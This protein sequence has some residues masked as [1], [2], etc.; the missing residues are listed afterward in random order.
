MCQS[1]SA[2]V[3]SAVIAMSHMFVKQRTGELKKVSAYHHFRSK[4]TER[5]AKH[6]NR[7]L[8]AV[9][10]RPTIS[11][12]FELIMFFRPLTPDVV[13]EECDEDPSETSL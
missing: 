4:I 13:S 9:V 3:L 10:N 12:D 1:N 2:Q 6:L 8:R 11:C 7:I 5:R